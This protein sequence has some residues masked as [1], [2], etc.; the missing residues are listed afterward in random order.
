MYHIIFVLI[1]IMKTQIKHKWILFL[2]VMSQL[3]LIC[4][5][6]YWLNSQYKVEKDALLKDMYSYYKQFNAG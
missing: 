2:M 6:L 5:A 1:S 4:F 3:L